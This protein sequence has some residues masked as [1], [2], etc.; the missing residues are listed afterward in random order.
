[1]TRAFIAILLVRSAASPLA[2]GKPDIRSLQRAYRA[3]TLGE[4]SGRERRQLPVTETRQQPIDALA[5][6]LLVPREG[7]PDAQ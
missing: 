3:V 7:F 6:E 2:G 1:M 4:R 5:W